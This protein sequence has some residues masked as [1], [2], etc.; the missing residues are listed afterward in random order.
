MSSMCWWSSSTRCPV[1][2]DDA[3]S[4]STWCS[5]PIRRL[6]SAPSPDGR[7]RSCIGPP[8]LPSHTHIRSF[9][10]FRCRHLHILSRLFVCLSALF[11][12]LLSTHASRKFPCSSLTLSQSAA[13]PPHLFPSSL[14]L[15]HTGFLESTKSWFL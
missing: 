13:T 5:S 3:T 14:S 10:S 9:R 7:R 1:P 11:L 15:V 6:A 2:H 12:F 8:A 4:R